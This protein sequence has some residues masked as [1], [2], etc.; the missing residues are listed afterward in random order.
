M[1]Y[2]INPAAFSA[3]FTVPAEVADRHLKLAKGG[4]I[5]ALLYI[6]RNMSSGIDAAVLADKCGI[7]EYEAKEALLYWADAGIL[8]PDNPQPAAEKIK[9]A[10]VKK[11]AK[12]A[13]GDVARRGAEDGKI[14]YL[15]QET[16]MR[17][18]RNLKSNETSTLVWLY[19]DQGM[20]VSLILMIVQ[21]AAAHNKANMRFIES[22]AVD[23]LDRGIDTVSAADEELRKI[24]M[25]EEAWRIVSAVFGLER[26]KPSKK[27]TELSLKWINEWKISKEMLEAAYDAC[28]DAKSKFSFAYVAKIIESWNEKGY[29]KPEDI[30]KRT[31]TAGAGEETGYAAYDLELFEEMLNKKD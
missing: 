31:G 3:V 25:G 13:R 8:M 22:T 23:W 9:P 4:H 5:K 14:K 29:K 17:F 30:E 20:D 2:Y 19:D 1:G 6:M 16:Q 27:E 21:Y 24:A 10:A 7:T 15:L 12:P 11:Q 18:G 26:R 28:V